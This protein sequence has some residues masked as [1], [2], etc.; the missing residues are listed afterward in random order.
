MWQVKIRWF[1]AWHAVGPAFSDRETADS[2]AVKWAKECK[3][4]IACIVERLDV[5]DDE[6]VT[7]DAVLGRGRHEEDSG[8]DLRNA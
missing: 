5:D 3:G 7:L 1:G 6:Y 8:C 4:T 2:A